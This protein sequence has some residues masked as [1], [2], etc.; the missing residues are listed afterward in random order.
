MGALG[1]LA[2]AAAKVRTGATLRAAARWG[3]AALRERKTC[4]DSMAAVEDWMASKVVR[5]RLS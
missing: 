1:S 3:A 2:A 5:D 4:R